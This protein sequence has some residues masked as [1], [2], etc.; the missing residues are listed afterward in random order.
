MSGFFGRLQNFFTP[1]KTAKSWQPLL[2]DSAGT[3]VKPVKRTANEEHE[4]SS[5]AFRGRSAAKTTGG[6]KTG[7][8]E[9][10]ERDDEM[11]DALMHSL[12]TVKAQAHDIN[13]SLDSQGKKIDTVTMKVDRSNSRIQK[14]SLKTKQI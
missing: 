7:V 4:V 10:L 12:R 2:N 3:T 11:L 13:G 9:H 5:T 6:A 14:Q 8:E 1:D